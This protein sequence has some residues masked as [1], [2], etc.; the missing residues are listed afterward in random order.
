MIK[1]IKYFV[2]VMYMQ[3]IRRHITADTNT[4]LTYSLGENIQVYGMHAWT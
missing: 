4:N 2:D 3:C 1:N